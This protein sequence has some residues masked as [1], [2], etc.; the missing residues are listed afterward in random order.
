[1]MYPKRV[2]D[3]CCPMRACTCALLSTDPPSVGASRCK[4]LSKELGHERGARVPQQTG[5]SEHRGDALEWR[6]VS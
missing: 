6:P 4:G 5:T 1:M 3:P 2:P